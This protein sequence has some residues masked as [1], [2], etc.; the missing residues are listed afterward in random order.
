MDLRTDEK[1]REV[2]QRDLVDQTVIAVAHRIG[3]QDRP[4][5]VL[6]ILNTCTVATI[7]DFDQILVLEDGHVLEYGSPQELLSDPTSRFSRLAASQGIASGTQPR[8]P[9]E[10]G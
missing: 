5:L 7:V 2:V 9:E 6:L 1:I 8:G 10:Q 4:Y 3:E